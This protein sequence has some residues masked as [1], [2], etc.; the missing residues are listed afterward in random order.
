MHGAR[1]KKSGRKNEKKVPPLRYGM[2]DLFFTSKINKRKKKESA[3]SR[4][5]NK[6]MR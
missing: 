5:P 4:F 2:T 3:E 1:I 6:R